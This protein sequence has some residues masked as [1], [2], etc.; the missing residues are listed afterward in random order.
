MVHTSKYC[1]YRGIIRRRLGS[2]KVDVTSPGQH[3]DRLRNPLMRG[4]WSEKHKGPL[5]M[6][7]DQ[8]VDQCPVELLLDIAAVADAGAGNRSQIGGFGIR[9]R[10]AS[11]IHASRNVGRRGIESS[12]FL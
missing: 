9:A 12:L 4:A 3:P 11:V 10:I 7:S 6:A 5:R 8:M 2:K 1:G